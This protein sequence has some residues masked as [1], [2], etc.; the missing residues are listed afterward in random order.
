MSSPRL[1]ELP[2]ELLTFICE[3]VNDA[4]Q[5]SV[6]SFALTSKQFSRAAGA[7]RFSRIRL[8]GEGPQQ[9]LDDLARFDDTLTR[10]NAFPR[11]RDLQVIWQPTFR[12]FNETTSSEETELWKV[13]W[14]ELASLIQNLPGLT[15][16]T[17]DSEMPFPTILLPILH[18]D[19][20]SVCRLHVTQFCLESLVGP[21]FDDGSLGDFE[22]SAD[23]HLLATSPCLHSVYVQPTT[24]IRERDLNLPAVQQLVQGGNPALKAVKVWRTDRYPAVAP[25][26]PRPGQRS[27]EWRGISAEAGRLAAWETLRLEDYG[28]TS[29]EVVEQWHRYT[30]FASLRSLKLAGASVPVLRWIYANSRDD[31]SAF[32]QLTCLE[33]EAGQYSGNEVAQEVAHATQ[34]VLRCLPPLKD[35]ALTGRAFGDYN[36][37]MSTATMSTLLQHHGNTLLRLSLQQ[38]WHSPPIIKTLSDANNLVERCPRLDHLNVSIARSEGDLKEVAI[39]QQLGSHPLLQSINLTLDCTENVLHTNLASP[40]DKIPW[41]GHQHICNGHIRRALKNCALDCTLATAIFHR[42][43][44]AKRSD[45]VQLKSMKIQV[46]NQGIFRLGQPAND[47][48]GRHLSPET[49]HPMFDHIGERPWTV[50]PHPNEDLRG[51]LIATEGVLDESLYDEPDDPITLDELE[52][53]FYNIWPKGK[54]GDWRN[55]WHSFPL[56]Q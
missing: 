43:A 10:N 54:T 25:R 55:D 52:E 49:L 1:Q 23:D 7:V 13:A 38:N 8:K 27:R 45:A 31:S 32:S 6:I 56:A 9:L 36:D 3:A 17:Y 48:Y 41:N 30:D 14:R 18:A 50:I 40:S 39:Y 4:Y 33:L 12:L 21:P 44:A 35:L 34:E 28:T 16:L 19:S 11:V 24:S 26:R 46:S 47:L 51:E 22:L 15:D 42:C 53:P 29:L 2:L 20:R 5:P 37:D